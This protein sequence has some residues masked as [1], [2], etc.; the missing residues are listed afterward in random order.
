VQES[1]AR[2]ALETSRSYGTS[3]HERDVSVKVLRKK[4]DVEIVVVM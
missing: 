1:V 2:P 4:G 3:S